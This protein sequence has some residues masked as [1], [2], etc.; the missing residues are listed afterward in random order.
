MS[1]L[2]LHRLRGFT[3][4]EV[5]IVV[6]VV[7]VLTAIALPSYNSYVQKSRRSD[8][9]SGL[10]EAANR[11]QQFV[12]NRSTF[13]V[14]MRDLGYATNPARSPDG[15]YTISSAQCAGAVPLTRCY[16]LTATP[17]GPQAADAACT[18]FTLGSNGAKAATGTSAATCW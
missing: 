14:D 10:M 8:A 11:Q 2:H 13:T 7:G 5:M 3:L 17:V 15:F 1:R 6:A 16:L 12:L 9:R 4:I 18:S